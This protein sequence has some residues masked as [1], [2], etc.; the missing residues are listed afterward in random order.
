VLQDADKPTPYR[1]RVRAAGHESLIAAVASAA[2]AVLLARYPEQ[3]AGLDAALERS[4]A[5]VPDGL[6]VGYAAGVLG[7]ACTVASWSWMAGSGW[8]WRPRCG[9]GWPPPGSRCPTTAVGWS[10]T[11]GTVAL[12]RKTPTKPSE[13]EATSPEGRQEGLE[14]LDHGYGLPRLGGEVEAARQGDYSMRVSVML[15]VP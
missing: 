9:R 6:A 3:Q 8:G 7:A 10:A 14:P 4:L 5:E 2:H 15:R 13:V 1:A 12:S 11:S